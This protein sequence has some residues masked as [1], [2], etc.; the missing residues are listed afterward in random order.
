MVRKKLPA[1]SPI[2]NI[3]LALETEEA[4]GGIPSPAPPQRQTLG[5]PELLTLYC[6]YHPSLATLYPKIHKKGN[7]CVKEWS[8]HAVA[9]GRSQV[10]APVDIRTLLLKVRSSM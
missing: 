7:G 2:A 9:T 10:Q 5:S 8:V 1:K 6:P 4:E 3:L